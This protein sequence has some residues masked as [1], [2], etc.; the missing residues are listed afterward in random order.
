MQPKTRAE[1]ATT[2]ASQVI[3]FNLY[4]ARVI[5]VLSVTFCFREE[6]L[7]ESLAVHEVDEEVRGVAPLQLPK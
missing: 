2:S 6:V 1:R 5:N 3:L 7:N 4:V